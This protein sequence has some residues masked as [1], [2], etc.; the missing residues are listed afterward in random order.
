MSSIFASRYHEYLVDK[1]FWMV[2]KEKPSWMPLWMYRAVIK[3]L[4][5]QIN[6]DI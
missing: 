2:V 6:E 3:N 5:D 4:I 1:N